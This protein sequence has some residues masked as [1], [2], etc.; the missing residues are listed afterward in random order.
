MCNNTSASS[1]FV[2]GLGLGLGLGLDNGQC[3][4]VSSEDCCRSSE[5]YDSQF[6]K[7][8]GAEFCVFVARHFISAFPIDCSIAKS[9]NLKRKRSSA[10]SN[11]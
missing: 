9:R 10:G 4:S 3:N 1:G 11:P 2:L 8:K 6:F 7:I 5:L